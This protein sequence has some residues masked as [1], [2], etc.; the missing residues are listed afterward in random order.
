MQ[1]GNIYLKFLIILIFFTS[2]RAQVLFFPQ[3]Q[4]IDTK[5]ISNDST[6]RIDD[7]IFKVKKINKTSA[8]FQ[9]TRV[10]PD[11]KVYYSFHPNLPQEYIPQFQQAFSAWQ[12]GTPLQFIER[13][14]ENQLY[15]DCTK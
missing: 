12:Q 2:A 9:E 14:T 7:M 13:T 4:T 1:S 8:A 5:A 3:N 6:I 15:S 11:A 10:W